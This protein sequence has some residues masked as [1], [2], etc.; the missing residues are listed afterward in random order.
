MFGYCYACKCTRFAHVTRTR[1][2]IRVIPLQKKKCNNSRLAIETASCKKLFS[3]SQ[4]IGSVVNVKVDLIP[5]PIFHP[6]ILFFSSL[7]GNFLSFLFFVRV[8]DSLKNWASCCLCF[9]FLFR[10][11]VY[12]LLS[13]RF[14]HLGW[15]SEIRLHKN[16]FLD[17]NV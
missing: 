9:L 7:M 4:S 14:V 13:M 10:N 8:L 15:L 11:S 17:I 3:T 5:F 6:W 2:Y 1:L 12:F 16:L